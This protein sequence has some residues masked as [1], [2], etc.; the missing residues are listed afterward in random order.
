MRKSASNHVLFWTVQDATNKTGAPPATGTIDSNVART[1]STS[2]R[3]RVQRRKDVEQSNELHRLDVDDLTCNDLAVATGERQ[4][5]S[6]GTRFLTM[7][8]PLPSGVCTLEYSAYV[9]PP[10]ANAEISTPKFEPALSVGHN[11]VSDVLTVLPGATLTGAH[12]DVPGVYPRWGCASKSYC[13][14]TA[15]PRRSEG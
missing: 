2:P 12:V 10:P 7:E 14:T 15:Y 8:K 1:L 11:A 6:T 9:P 3:G 5:D 13:D 4:H